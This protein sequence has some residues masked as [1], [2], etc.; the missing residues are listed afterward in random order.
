MVRSARASSGLNQRPG[1]SYLGPLGALLLEAIAHEVAVPDDGGVEPFAHVLEVALEG[2]ERDAEL[3][4]EF[5]HLD[6][7]AARLQQLV[8]LVEALGPVH[9]EV[10]P[11]SMRAGWLA[12]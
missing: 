10:H 6:H 12:G 5:A 8:D 4:E 11:R 3:V 1:S 9:G 7:R 2:G